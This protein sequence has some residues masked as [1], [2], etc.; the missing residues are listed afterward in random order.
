MK[1]RVLGTLEV[2]DDQGRTVDVGGAHQR[3]VLA[4]LLAASGRTVP[5]ATIV[6]PLV[7]YH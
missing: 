2:L 1:F 7:R 6:L 4:R 5:V 3:T